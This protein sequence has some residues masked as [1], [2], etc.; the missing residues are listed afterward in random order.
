MTLG[1][2]KR[3]LTVSVSRDDLEGD[4]KDWINRG[5]RAVQRD[6]S[7]NCMRHVSQVTMADGTSS[8]AMPGDFKEMQIERG[9]VA[10]IDASNTRIPVDIVTREKLIGLT[11][12]TMPQL[13]RPSRT[14]VPKLFLS[15]DGN[16]AFLNMLDTTTG[17]ASFEVAYFRYLPNLE[18][19]NDENYITR[20]FED[21]VQA[22]VKAVAFSV[23]NDP[24]A[25]T[26]MGLYKIFKTEA[27][28][29]D[30]KQRT[31]GRTVQMG[32]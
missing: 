6:F 20:E 31:Q 4:Y 25:A 17:P 11:A 14:T 29:F 28:G 27:I 1:E 22:R 2:L 30:T 24:Q 26:E 19:D 23:I 3:M 10:L 9:S 15:N 16:Q 12:M 18:A 13:V 8:V 5:I 32:G 7:Y 21:M